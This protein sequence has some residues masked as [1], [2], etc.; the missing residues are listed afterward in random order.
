MH[1]CKPVR[2][3]RKKNPIHDGAWLKENCVK[4]IKTT[5]QKNYKVIILR[6]FFKFYSKNLSR[7]V[8]KMRVEKYNAGW[9]K[10]VWM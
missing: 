5:F 2:N 10:A 7:K 1:N 9:K 4:H 6:K 8:D 3:K